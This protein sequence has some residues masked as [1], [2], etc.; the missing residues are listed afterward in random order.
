VSQVDP[1]LSTVL[2]AI[3]KGRE[4]ARERERQRVAVLEQVPLFA[5][6][7]HRHLRHLAGV[8]Q[9]RTFLPGRTVVEKG[10]AGNSF[11]VVVDGTAKVM[12]GDSNRVLA[13]IRRGDFFGELSLLDGGP[14]TA[15]VLAETPL[16]VL[17]IWRS[18]FRALIKN[19]PDVSLKMMQELARRLREERSPTQ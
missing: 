8:A 13:R 6:L 1:R 12:L 18:D 5:G 9:E 14:R 2:P 7:S 19:E 3:T 15:S 10:A 11:Y 16:T 4:G 17:K